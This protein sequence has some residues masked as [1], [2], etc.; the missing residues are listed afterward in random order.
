M[1]YFFC[2]KMNKHLKNKYIDTDFT[3]M[4]EIVMFDSNERQQIINS[5]SG[6]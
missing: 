2:A 5:S 3:L 4:K 6:E 1:H